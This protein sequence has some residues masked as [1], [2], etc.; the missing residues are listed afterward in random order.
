MLFDFDGVIIDSFD[1]VLKINQARN[2][3]LTAEQYR[4]R[5]DGPIGDEMARTQSPAELNTFFAAYQAAIPG[6]PIVPDIRKVILDLRQQYHLAVISST[7]TRSIRSFLEAHR[8]LDAF[9]VILGYDVNPDKTAKIAEFL[10]EERVIPAQALFITDTLGD[11]DEARKAGVETIGVTWGFHTADDL[12]KGQ[13]YEIITTPE[14]LPPVIEHYFS[15][16][17]T[18]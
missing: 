11:V 3:K 16:T 2:N 12:K 17:A 4:R 18:L 15:T 13:P 5:F 14:D 10:C 7:Y 9:Q 6:M 1:A 8:M